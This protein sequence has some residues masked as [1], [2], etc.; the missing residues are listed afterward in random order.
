MHGIITTSMEDYLEAIFHIIREKNVARSKDICQALNVSAPSVTKA[1]KVLAERK[2]VNYAPRELITLTDAG[3]KAAQDVIYRHEALCDFL[4]TVLHIDETEADETACKMEHNVSL[5]VIKRIILYSEFVQ[6]CPRSVTDWTNAYPCNVSKDSCET[7]TANCLSSIRK[8]TS[9]KQANANVKPL[10]QMTSAQRGRIVAITASKAVTKKF[11]DLG[12]V[13]GG[14]VELE[15]NFP[16]EQTIDI[17]VRG[18]HHSLLK[19]EAEK[20]TIEI[21]EEH[22]A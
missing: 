2:L 18:Y 4:I 7:C 5:D 21:L 9:S 17:K 16:D 19:H 3:R 12:L 15:N 14:F 6:L 22:K 8:M 10:T 11:S 13:C 1:L 20:I